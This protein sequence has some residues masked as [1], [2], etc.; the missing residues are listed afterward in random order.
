MSFILSNFL[1]QLAE[2]GLLK[3]TPQQISEILDLDDIWERL[4]V[5]TWELDAKNNGRSLK[6]FVAFIL[7]DLGH[8]CSTFRG[9][10]L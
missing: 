5:P 2:N 10:C 8:V 4:H 3:K 7:N 1:N 9:R 6:T